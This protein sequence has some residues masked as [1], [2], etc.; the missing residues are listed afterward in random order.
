MTA[1]K[2][3]SPPRPE[4]TSIQA[5]LFVADIK[6]ACDLYAVKLGFEIVFTYGEPPFYGQVRRGAARFNLRMICEPAFASDIR[7]RETLLAAS[8]AV[9]SAAELKASYEEF[10]AAGAA[11]HQTLKQQPWGAREFIV[12]DPDGNLLHFAGP[13]V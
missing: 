6:A 3:N 4:P 8:I 10:E 12:R 5:Q 11:L 7:E 9:D 13:R 2:T 1:Q